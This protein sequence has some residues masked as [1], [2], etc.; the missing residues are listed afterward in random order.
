MS[1]QEYVDG[2]LVGSG[3]VSKAAIIGHDG[4]SWAH[5]AGFEVVGAEAQKVVSAFGDTT[6][7]KSPGYA[8]ALE[9]AANGIYINGKKYVVFRTSEVTV[10]ARLGATGIHCVKTNMCILIG[11]YDENIQANACS[12]T[13][14]GLG[15]HLRNSGY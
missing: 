4:T 13:V 14:E 8:G 12:M 3:K 15:D 10:Q 5:S 7:P 2:Q 1:W 6:D 11:Y 9:A